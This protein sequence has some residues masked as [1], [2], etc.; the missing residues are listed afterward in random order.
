MYT[1]Q[2]VDDNMR[3]PEPILF[4]ETPTSLL[5]HSL[6]GT[7]NRDLLTDIIWNSPPLDEYLVINIVKCPEFKEIE[8]GYPYDISSVRVEDK[9]L[10]LSSFNY[11]NNMW[12][13]GTK[14]S[15]SGLMKSKLGRTLPVVLIKMVV[16]FT[17]GIYEPPKC[18][19]SQDQLIS[20]KY[21]CFGISYLTKSIYCHYCSA[22]DEWEEFYVSWSLKDVTIC[23][24]DNHKSDFY[25]ISQKNLYLS[26]GK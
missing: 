19:I 3:K 8:D 20:D 12:K 2:T 15:V 21:S 11:N 17:Y 6:D 9:Q 14:A 24:L 1:W 4:H 26:D 5:Y 10:L 16:N 18:S 13:W 7:L 23:N 25:H 22:H